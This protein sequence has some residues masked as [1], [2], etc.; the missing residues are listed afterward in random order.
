MYFLICTFFFACVWV[1]FAEVKSFMKQTTL[2]FADQYKTY[3]IKCLQVNYGSFINLQ[4]L[5]YYLD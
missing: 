2:R 4:A 3:E 5:S 1:N